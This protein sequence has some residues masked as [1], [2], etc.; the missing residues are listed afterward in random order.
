MH[1]HVSKDNILDMLHGK[2]RTRLRSGFSPLV[3]FYHEGADVV[4]EQHKKE[5]LMPPLTETQSNRE[6]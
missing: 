1:I 5:L 3:T 4:T 2:E 6:I